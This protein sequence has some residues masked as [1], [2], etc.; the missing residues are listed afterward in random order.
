MD[1]F[2]RMNEEQ[3]RDMLNM[4]PKNTLVDFTITVWQHAE[5]MSDLYENTVDKVIESAVK[6]NNLMSCLEEVK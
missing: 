1:N 6:M 2:K 3:R 5:Y 4:L